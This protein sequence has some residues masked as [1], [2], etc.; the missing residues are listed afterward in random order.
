ML[1]LLGFAIVKVT[2]AAVSPIQQ[3]TPAA[4]NELYRPTQYFSNDMIHMFPLS[5]WVNGYWKQ[6][7]VFVEKQLGEPD[8]LLHILSGQGSSGL[9]L[10]ELYVRAHQGCRTRGFTVEWRWHRGF[11]VS[12]S[13][14]VKDGSSGEG[15]SLKQKRL[16][17][18]YQ[19]NQSTFICITH[20]YK[21]QFV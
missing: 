1:G 4:A 11:Y 17:S 16:F 6:S 5:C 13:T 9:E 15:Y 10:V 8:K 19:S 20:V 18:I 14:R 2:T 21:L 12:K 3:H 7:S